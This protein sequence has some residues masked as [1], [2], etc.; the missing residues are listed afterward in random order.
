MPVNNGLILKTL[1]ECL[2]H[3]APAV[4]SSFDACE[5]EIESIQKELADPKL[6]PKKAYQ[7][8]ILLQSLNT[9]LRHSR[10][11]VATVLK[12]LLPLVRE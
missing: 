4:M 8:K 1:T 7:L 2:T 11:K 3:T 10:A 12:A 6:S 9:Q 5:A